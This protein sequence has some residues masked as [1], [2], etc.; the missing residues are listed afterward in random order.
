MYHAKDWATDRVHRRN[1]LTLW[2]RLVDQQVWPQ[3]VNTPGQIFL[4]ELE[5]SGNTFKQNLCLLSTQLI[6]CKPQLD[7]V[8]VFCCYYILLLTL[9]GE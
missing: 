3:T 7:C 1:V 9:K 5:S 8:S 2:Q 6:S 4:Q